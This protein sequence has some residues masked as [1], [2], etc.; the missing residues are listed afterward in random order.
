MEEKL[1]KY[2]FRRS[3]GLI[4]AN[5]LQMDVDME[6][7]RGSRLITGVFLFVMTI[8][9]FCYG[10]RIPLFVVTVAAFC[11]FEGIVHIAGIKIFRLSKP[12]TPGMVTAE[13][14]LLT[15]IA[16]LVYLASNHLAHWYDYLFGHSSSS[17]ALSSCNAPSWQWLASATRICSP[18][19]RGVSASRS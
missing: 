7:K 1:K 17:P 13:I 2:K 14:E 3:F 9:P 4:S 18:L 12:Y 10:D 11:I 5:V 19:S 6:T 8:V 16:L 15:G